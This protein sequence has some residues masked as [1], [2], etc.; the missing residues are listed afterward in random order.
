M[1]IQ[2][3]PL[4]TKMLEKDYMSLPWQ[5]WFRNVSKN[6]ED[7]CIIYTKDNLSYN[8]Q[9]NLMLINYVGIG[10][11]ID[12]PYTVSVDSFITYYTQTGES[13]LIDIPKGTQKISIPNVYVRIKDFILVDQKNR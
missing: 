1:R 3:A 6:L 12:I 13:Y 4:T 7:T 11:D 8:L 5:T 9:G 10:Q 2:P